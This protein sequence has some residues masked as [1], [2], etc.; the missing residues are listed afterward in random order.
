[1]GEETTATGDM[2]DAERKAL[3]AE[4]YA[5]RRVIVAAGVS[6]TPH[7]C[8]GAREPVG[9]SRSA[10]FGVDADEAAAILAAYSE[11][12]KKVEKSSGNPLTRP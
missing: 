5:L 3:E 8:S 9:Y 11:A 2:S 6:V 1:M 7:P 12:G 4:L 10:C